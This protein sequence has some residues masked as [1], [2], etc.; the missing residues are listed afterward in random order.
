MTSTT[1]PF[2]GTRI[3]VTGASSGIGREIAIRFATLGCESML[4]HFHRNQDGANETASTIA[5]TGCDASIAS[6]D[7]SDAQQASDFVDAAFAK[8]TRVDVWIHCAGA[9]VLTG[10]AG[11]WSF[12]RKLRHLINVD[13]I[14]SIQSGRRVGALM[15]L[16]ARASSEALSDPSAPPS[17]ALIGWDQASQGMEG[18]AG[19]MFGPVK[20]AVEAF[21]KSL[22]QDLAPQVRVNT[23]LPG[24]IQT[25]WGESTSEYWNRRAGGQSLMHRWGTPADVA[26]AAAYVSNPCHTFVTGQS[27]EVNGGWNRKFTGG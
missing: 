22:A 18:D 16:Q 9:D 24:W 21:A 7:F 6:C 23:I 20:A 1:R 17:I 13:V 3:V 15:K 10:E 12:E 2:A 27:I 25:Q 11:G 4:V 14:G 5:K 19:Q 26:A 8:L